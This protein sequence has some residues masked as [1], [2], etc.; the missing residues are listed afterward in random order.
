MNVTI[1]AAVDDMLGSLGVE[2]V[3]ARVTDRGGSG[4]RRGDVI[5][6]P[7]GAILLS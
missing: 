1:P 3:A 4:R 6:M 5:G 7:C 2:H